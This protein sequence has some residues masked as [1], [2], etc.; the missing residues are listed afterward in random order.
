M[1]QIFS[2]AVIASVAAS[3][4]WVFSGQAKA[5]PRQVGAGSGEL[6]PRSCKKLKSSSCTS[7]SELGVMDI[8]CKSGRV[9]K[10]CSSTTTTCTN[11]A[12]CD[13]HVGG[14]AC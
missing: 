1:K 6:V 2:M 9:F 14:A 8:E 4:M 13:A 10:E 5:A 11:G 7:C 3:A 12:S